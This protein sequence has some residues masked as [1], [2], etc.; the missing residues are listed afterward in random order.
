MENYNKGRTERL[1]LKSRSADHRWFPYYFFR[2][3]NPHHYY[4]I[5]LWQ[6]RNRLKSSRTRRRTHPRS[7]KNGHQPTP[8]A[9]GRN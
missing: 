2:I 4:K 8:Y 3:D 1:A 6:K 5:Q 9:A 7:C